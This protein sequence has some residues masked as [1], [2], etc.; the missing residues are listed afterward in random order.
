MLWTAPL[1]AHESHGS[2]CCLRPPRFGGAEQAITTIGL[3][4]AK[5]VFQVHGVDADRHVGRPPSLKRRYVMAFFKKLRARMVGIEACAPSHHWYRGATSGD[6]RF[7][8][9][10]GPRKAP[11]NPRPILRPKPALTVVG[12][13]NGPYGARK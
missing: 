2:E 8:W 13:T 3:D 6:R 11:W 9:C 7:L 4:M 12:W 1:P 5:S 10:D